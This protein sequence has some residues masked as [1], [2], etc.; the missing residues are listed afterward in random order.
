M[1]LMRK[2]RLKPIAAGLLMVFGIHLAVSIAYAQFQLPS[3]AEWT[4]AEP[5]VGVASVTESTY[6]VELSYDLND[7]IAHSGQSWEFST[8]ATGDEVIYYSW[9]Y[10]GL[11]A[12][13]DAYASVTAFVEHEGA[14]SPTILLDETKV[15]GE[16][17]F[18][19]VSSFNVANG[20]KYGFIIYGKNFDSN[21]FLQGT[22]KIG[23]SPLIQPTL[24]GTTGS[25]G[26]YTSDVNLS[27][28]LTDPA[29]SEITA[30]GCGPLTV[31]TDTP[32]EGSTYTCTAA[33]SG[34][35]SS[36]S[37]T[38]KR[39]T[40]AP[41]TIDNAP[42]GVSDSSV[43]VDLTASDDSSGVAS[44][45]YTVNEGPQQTGTS[46]TFTLDGTHTLTY[47]SVDAAGNIESPKT[48][49]ILVDK[50]LPDVLFS[51][52]PVVPTKQNVIVTITYPD[53]AVIKQISTDQESWESYEAPYVANENQ[54]IYARYADEYGTWSEVQSYVIANIDRVPPAAPVITLSTTAP[55]EE[56]T[57][58]I[59]Y[60]SD[61][62][63]RQYQLWGDNRSTYTGPF[64]LTQNRTI[65]AYAID[66]AGN[67]S[68]A[69]ISI[70][71][72][73][74]TPPV[75]T[76]APYDDATPTN[77]PITVTASTNEGTLNTHSHTFEDNGTFTFIA[78][79]LAGNVTTKDVTI[80]NIDVIPPVITI[81]PYDGSTPTNQ[82]I[83]VF[84][85]AN[86]GTLNAESHTFTEN[87]SFTFSAVDEVGNV[88]EEVITITNIDL[89]G[90]I[91]TLSEYDGTMS[92]NQ[93]IT[94][95][96]STNEGML[97]AES[98]TFTENGKF[99]FRAVD[100]A[101]NATDVVVTITNID[102]IAPIITLSEYDDTTPTNQA[103][104][105]YASTNEGT[106]NAESH[107]FTE[108]GT[109]TF[110]AADEAGN[111][112]EEVVAIAVIDTTAPV[113]TA[114]QTTDSTT[115]HVSLTLNVHD[116]NIGDVT[117]YYTIDG[118]QHTGNQLVLN[119][120]GAHLI[121]YWSVDAA[122][123]L[124]SPNSLEVKVAILQLNAHGTIGIDEIVK[125]TQQGSLF[126][127]DMNGDQVFDRDDI[128]IMLTYMRPGS[129]N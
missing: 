63:V 66:E 75:I 94:V 25:N 82:S 24:V 12:W 4:I 54:T 6:G 125:L 69:T 30:S 7:Y 21:S 43:T 95:Y 5:T 116:Q 126:Q 107:T 15:H 92:T 72:L 38:I 50:L 112:T 36:S 27:W 41:T 74:M 79:D 23:T 9:D 77:Q 100:E 32:S 113:T 98:H 90:P 35:T 83:T 46:V 52:N 91:I 115:K 85:S 119:K 31:T 56:L 58:S 48:A 40:T 118:I 68:D 62:A 93:A 76:I 3:T 120:Q 45:H 20:D 53:I 103:I 44:T 11:H 61:A 73:D 127:Q 37:V 101:G 42:E 87:G 99:T 34:G 19:G 22:L 10:S 110:I 17:R 71:N 8:E 104:T 47:W 88:T 106:L 89:T 39:D 49:T 117:T 65:S 109:F 114:V 16:F 105:V 70:V 122:G 96:A 33:S 13:Y 57:V 1:K 111:V 124:E 59:E 108:N 80:S 84:A 26:W 123:N 102:L 121:T 97:N 18:A 14:R 29:S 60:P 55:A 28:A 81:A 2:S 64:V 67:S 78:T 129:M 86:E 128:R 51:A